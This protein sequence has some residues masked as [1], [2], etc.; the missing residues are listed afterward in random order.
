MSDAARASVNVNLNPHLLSQLATK[1]GAPRSLTVHQSV[2][3]SRSQLSEPRVVEAR[4]SEALAAVQ[5]DAAT[6]I[7]S[8]RF[9]PQP[10]VL[11]SLRLR[12]NALG[13]AGTK[14]VA[15][16]LLLRAPL[17]L[18]VLSLACVGAGDAGVAALAS[19]LGATSA[20]HLV[21]LDLS[22][23]QL[24]GAVGPA[25][26]ALL[27]APNQWLEELRLS[28]NALG[29]SGVRSLSNGLLANTALRH[30]GLA[31]VDVSPA[32]VRSLAASLRSHRRLDSLSLPGNW[33]LAGETGCHALA[34]L[35]SCATVLDRLWVGDSELGVGGAAALASGLEIAATQRPVDPIAL[36]PMAMQL[37]PRGPAV[38]GGGVIVGGIDELF[39]GPVGGPIPVRGHLEQ[40]QPESAH[41]SW[42]GGG[43]NPAPTF[44]DS[45]VGVA[46]LS[47]LWL[48]RAQLHTEGVAGVCTLL[49][50]PH[51]AIRELWLGGNFLGDVAAF[52]ISSVLGSSPALRRLHLERNE[53][54]IDG[55]LALLEAAHASGSLQ[56]LHLDGNALSPSDCVALHSGHAELTA[57]RE[58]LLAHHVGAHMGCMP[59][60]GDEARGLRLLLRDP[61]AAPRGVATGGGS[62]A[63]VGDAATGAGGKA[64]L[65][66]PSAKSGP[67]PGRPWR[68]PRAVALLPDELLNA[69]GKQGGGRLDVAAMTADGIAATPPAG[70]DEQ[71]M[72]QEDLEGGA[73]EGA[74]PS[75]SDD[76][77]AAPATET[78]DVVAP[79]AEA[80]P[81]PEEEADEPSEYAA[82]PAADGAPP[83]EFS[84]PPS[85]PSSGRASD[86][87]D[88]NG[89]SAY[90][91]VEAE[92]EAAV[93]ELEAAAA[94]ADAAR[95]PLAT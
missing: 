86:C 62:D 34:E 54:G 16:A 46:P 93:A 3:L 65:V 81:E 19:A 53:I 70:V 42:G 45:P 9:R 63:T 74:V 7:Q 41:D 1:V 52:E 44:A 8:C 11:I 4:V 2:D 64:V 32:G 61:S 29:D 58:E 48:E 90:E 39:D 15:Q 27:A 49:A 79:P 56:Q 59:A 43:H 38:A 89:T 75:P 95:S 28:R 13:D 51:A 26:A 17:T 6:E 83:S 77:S 78:A 72:E 91:A 12:E 66:S 14:A 94:E 87:V 10:N 40:Q 80:A 55:A 76:E 30:L 92:A 33:R 67:R 24:T 23:N 68:H 47:Y 22:S 71:T 21:S 20:V 84:A 60:Q 31:Q 82:A 69:S 37:S 73:D 18:R 50:S 5:A 85:P 25:L 88:G 35:I 57:R 36:A